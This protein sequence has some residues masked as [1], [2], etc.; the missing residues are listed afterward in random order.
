MVRK[1][2]ALIRYIFKIDPEQLS[3]EEWAMRWNEAHWLQ[4]TYDILNLGKMQM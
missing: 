1:C 4:E 3:E 2:N